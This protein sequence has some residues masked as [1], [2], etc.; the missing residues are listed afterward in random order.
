M[1]F[2]PAELV[3]G[4]QQLDP[5]TILVSPTWLYEMRASGSNVVVLDASWHMPAAGRN[6]QKEFEDKRIKGA[7]RFDIDGVADHSSGLPHMLP[8]ASVFADAMRSLGVASADTPVVLYDTVGVFS[9]PRAWWTLRAF[10]HKKVAILN[11]GLPRY[12][13]EGYETESGPLAASSASASSS[14]PAAHGWSLDKDRVRDLKQVLAVTGTGKGKPSDE[15]DEELVVDARSAARFRG[16]APEPRAGLASGHI[17]RS[18]NVPFDTILQ[19]PGNTAFLPAKDIKEVFAKAG[20]NVDRK[21]TIVTSCGS[22]ITASVLFTGLLLAGR[23]INGCALYDGSFTEYGDP[24]RNKEGKVLKGG[25][26]DE[27]E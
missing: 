20:V 8:S 7:R 6:P 21:G 5:T 13:A 15:G 19:Q 3:D 16:E 14:P 26:D 12:V 1:S 4:A 18:R 17:P 22:G 9:S 10:N 2:N 25:P 23:D 24:T 11:G 27:H